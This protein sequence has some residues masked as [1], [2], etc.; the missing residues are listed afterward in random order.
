MSYLYSEK[1]IVLTI[2]G[3]GELKYSL[4]YLDIKRYNIQC[5]MDKLNCVEWISKGQGHLATFMFGQTFI[6]S[7]CFL[8]LC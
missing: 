8:W 6:L 7:K 2:N 1:K 5:L 4:F 3:E